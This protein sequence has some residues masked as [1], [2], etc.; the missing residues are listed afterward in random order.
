MAVGAA[1]G[2][3]LLLVVED[4]LAER[5]AGATDV[6]QVI[7]VVDNFVYFTVVVSCVVSHLFTKITG[8]VSKCISP[9]VTIQA[10]HVFKYA[11]ILLGS[12]AI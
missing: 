1:S 11:W 10:I 12:C 9:F 3:L 7:E 8:L 6:H 2:S 4:A 5:Q